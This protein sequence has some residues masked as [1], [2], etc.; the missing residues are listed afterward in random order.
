MTMTKISFNIWSFIRNKFMTH[1]SKRFL[2]MKLRILSKRFL[3]IK[4][5]MRHGAMRVEILALRSNDTWPLV[6]FHSSMNVVSN[7]WVY[8]IKCRV[9]GSIERFVDK[10]VNNKKNSMVL[11]TNNAHQKNNYSLEYTERIISLVI[12]SGIYNNFIPTLW[13]IL[14][15]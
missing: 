12:G 4:L 7:C 14:N 2:L 11:Q 1:S 13:N 5:G 3:L 9:D 6:P 8:R 10:S 15:E